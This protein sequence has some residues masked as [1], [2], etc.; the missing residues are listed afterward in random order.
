MRA[1]TRALIVEDIETWIYTLDRAAR[2]AGASEIVACESLDAAREALRSARFDV[3]ILDIGLDP[4]DDLNSDGIKVLEAIRGV[5]R[6]RHPVRP[7]HRLAGRRPAGPAVG[8]P[9]RST[10]STG[11][12]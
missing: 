3:A 1:P 10:A 5:R 12:S 7:G 11:P 8:R 4:G 9:A 6:R 2:R